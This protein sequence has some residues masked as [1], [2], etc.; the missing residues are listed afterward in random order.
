[1][2]MHLL[3]IITCFFLEKNESYNDLFFLD[4]GSTPHG[5]QSR[6]ASS[7]ITGRLR[8]DRAPSQNYHEELLEFGSIREP[9]K[10]TKRT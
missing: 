10:Q 1:M 9:A 4:G 7:S 2:H 3:F 6:S 5:P 8:F